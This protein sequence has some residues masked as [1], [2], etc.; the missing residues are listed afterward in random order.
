MGDRPIGRLSDLSEHSVLFNGNGLH[1][2][3]IELG[4]VGTGAAA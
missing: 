4:K 1:T 2:L 3:I